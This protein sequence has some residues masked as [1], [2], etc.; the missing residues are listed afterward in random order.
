MDGDYTAANFRIGA[1]GTYTDDFHSLVKVDSGISSCPTMFLCGLYRAWDIDVSAGEVVS[2]DQGGSQPWLADWPVQ[3][4]TGSDSK[5][6]P[7]VSSDF[8]FW[9]GSDNGLLLEPS[10]DMN[11]YENF[12]WFNKTDAYHSLPRKRSKRKI[13]LPVALN[14]ES[15]VFN[16]PVISFNEG[17]DY[18]ALAAGLVAVADDDELVPFKMGDIHFSNFKWQ[19]LKQIFF[20]EEDF[21][22]YSATDF[23]GYTSAAFY[24]VDD[25]IDLGDVAIASPVIRAYPI[26]GLI[27]GALLYN[28]P[29]TNGI[30]VQTVGDGTQLGVT[31]LVPTA[32]VGDYENAVYQSLTDRGYYVVPMGLATPPPYA[33]D[34]VDGIL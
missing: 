8:L 19:D 6:I 1:N 10:L 5:Q 27:V 20:F 9:V 13:N 28:E 31:I 29:G 17:S 15:A 4:T 7:L 2:M 24:A 11:D 34:P 21:E 14:S 26:S 18:A 3:F 22:D 12:A 30:Y 23:K 33:T 16:V 25:R 32:L